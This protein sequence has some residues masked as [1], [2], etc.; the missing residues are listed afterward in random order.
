MKFHPRLHYSVTKR[1]ENLGLG[2]RV[3]RATRERS[4]FW[5]T[6]SREC[7]RWYRSGNLQG[8]RFQIAA[9]I[10]YAQKF[11]HADQYRSFKD[12]VVGG[13]EI[14]LAFIAPKML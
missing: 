5:T 1:K 8:L 11:A 12:S 13:N 6:I 2:W 7:I 14:L 4:V 10:A 9:V 3:T